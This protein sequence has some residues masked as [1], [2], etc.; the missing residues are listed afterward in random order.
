MDYE[1]INN[2]G[3]YE[4]NAELKRAISGAEIQKAIG[5]AP[6][7]PAGGHTAHKPEGDSIEQ[8][9]R[10][11]FARVCAV[12][13]Y[14]FEQVE[15]AVNLCDARLN[16]GIVWNGRLFYLVEDVDSVNSCNDCALRKL[17]DNLTGDYYL[18]KAISGDSDHHFVM[19]ADDSDTAMGRGA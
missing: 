17:C 18:C 11:G 19:L 15:N 10:T 5:D 1:P 4:V 8:A 7:Y 3:G 14:G 13:L 12:L 6:H 16:P 2:Q 9:I